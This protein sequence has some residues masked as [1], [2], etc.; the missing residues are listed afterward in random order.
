MPQSCWYRWQA[1]C[2]GTSPVSGSPSQAAACAETCSTPSAT[3]GSS[4][5]SRSGPRRCRRPR[6]QPGGVDETISR[7]GSPQ[8]SSSFWPVGGV[9]STVS[10][11]APGG[12]SWRGRW[13][14]CARPRRAGPRRAARSGTSWCAADSTTTSRVPSP[15][16]STTASQGS[17]RTGRQGGDLAA[18]RV[19]AAD[20]AV[21]GVADGDRAVGQDRDPERVLQQRLRRPARPVAEVEKALCR[22]AVSHDEAVVVDVERA[23]RGG[24]GVGDPQ[25]LPSADAASPDGWAN[26]ASSAGAVDGGPRRRAAEHRTVLSA[27]SVSVHSWCMPAM[28]M[29]TPVDRTRPRPTARTGPLSAGPAAR[30]PLHCCARAGQERERAVGEPRPLSGGSRC[31]RRPRRT[32]TRAAAALRLAEPRLRLTVDR[33]AATEPGP[34]GLAVR[35]RARPAVVRRCRTPAEPSA[36]QRPSPGT[37][38]RSGGAGADIRRIAPAQRALGGVL[39]DELL[40]QDRQAVGVALARHAGRRCSPRGRPRPASARRGRCMPARSRA[41]GRRAPGGAR[42]TAPPRRRAASASASCSNFGECTPMI[43]SESAYFSSSSRSSS[44][45]CRQLMQQKVQ[46]SRTTIRPRRSARE[47]ARPPVLSQPRPVS[48]GA[49]RRETERGEVTRVPTRLGP[50][51]FPTWRRSLSGGGFLQWA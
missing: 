51:L 21:V 17:R 16:D 39:G 49:R 23:Q 1:A 43:T 28:A 14:R 41:R 10:A 32:P 35:P 11:T 25:R 44:S 31:R 12:D 27:G 5:R 50:R 45:T 37:A 4:P 34:L 15:S 8:R 38:A 18:R 30:R 20:R 29:T 9:K 48:S 6:Q 46:K 40:D 7:V 24:L 42:R 2:S 47:N 13:V 36:A 26:H 33:R 19:E 3:A 22:H